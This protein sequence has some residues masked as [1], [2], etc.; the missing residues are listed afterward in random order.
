MEK[1]NIRKRVTL[2]DISKE[3]GCSKSAISYVL[4]KTS[5][6]YS[7]ETE[8]RII[9]TAERL[10]YYP[11]AI[12]KRLKT[13]KTN[14]IAFI[15][16]YISDFFSEVFLGVQEAALKKNYSVALYSSES[17]AKQEKRNIISILSNRFDGII[18]VSAIM[19][20]KNI[21]KIINE[22]TP[23]ITI[24]NILKDKKIPHLNIRNIEISKKAVNYFISLGHK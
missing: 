10:G 11:D 1:S 7:K 9:E 6:F 3:T 4:N 21:E 16:P 22:G 24:E 23:M 18:V 17:S 13:K 12:A 19:N 14:N 15:V 20:E 8:K 5:K 2:K